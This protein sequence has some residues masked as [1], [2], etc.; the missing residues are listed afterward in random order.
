MSESDNGADRK[1]GKVKF[2]NNKKGYGFIIPDE[3]GDDV[4]VHHKALPE[5]VTEMQP[6]TKVSFNVVP[7]KRGVKAEGVRLS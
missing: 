5:G 7:D 3:G 6:D 4:F 1:T 2:Y